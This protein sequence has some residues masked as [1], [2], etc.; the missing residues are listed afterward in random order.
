MSISCYSENRYNRTQNATN[1]IPS[2]VCTSF[3]AHSESGTPNVTGHSFGRIVNPPPDS[4]SSIKK[5]C[6]RIS[7]EQDYIYIYIYIYNIY[8]YIFIFI[9]LFIYIV[10]SSIYVFWA[11]FAIRDSSCC[12]YETSPSSRFRMEPVPHQLSLVF[13]ATLRRCCKL[14]DFSVSH[15][16]SNTAISARNLLPSSPFSLTYKPQKWLAVLFVP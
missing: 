9:Y 13:L 12:A 3:H 7:K 16:A 4:D 8:I 10:Q 14:R 1:Q 6:T 5:T 15:R 2:T 11:F